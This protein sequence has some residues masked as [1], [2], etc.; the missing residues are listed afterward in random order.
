MQINGVDISRWHAR[1][2]AVSIGN[3][4]ITNNSEWNRGSPDPF[5]I[6]GTIGFKTLKVT[7]LIKDS[8]RELM[9]LDR[10]N[11]VA[12]L[13]EPADIILDGF[14]HKFR[15]VLSKD[16]SFE[17]TVGYRQDRWHK[18]T[19]EL[20]GYEYGPEISASGTTTLSI[21]NPGNLDTPAV[22]E[23]LPSISTVPIILR[24]IC[25][26]PD[27]GEDDPV[28]VRNLE[29]NKKVIIDG[30]T[31]LI[32][33]EGAQKA[34]DVD[35]WELPVLSPGVNEITCD[36]VNVTMTVRFKPRYM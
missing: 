25:R 12:S 7:L 9:T 36:N 29:T 6:G 16:A 11:I 28:T 5:M 4:A 30:E 19:L 23:L 14:A 22:L 17:E 2:W 21:T 31:G 10:S 26:S 13:L 24:G 1:Q 34:G 18:L 35:L 3:H 8:T 33:Q 15:M 27:T 32:T 20:Q